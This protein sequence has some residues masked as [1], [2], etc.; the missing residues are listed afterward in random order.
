MLTHR[1]LFG[2]AFGL[3]ALLV[4]AAPSCGPSPDQQVGGSSERAAPDTRFQ[5]V[6]A[7]T[8]ESVRSRRER[9]RAAA[10]HGFVIGRATSLLQSGAASSREAAERL[11]EIEYRERFGAVDTVNVDPKE[12]LHIVFHP[13]GMASVLSPVHTQ[14]DWDRAS[15]FATNPELFGAMNSV[16]VRRASVAIGPEDVAALSFEDES[17]INMRAEGRD[18]V[19]TLLIGNPDVEEGFALTIADR[20]F[21]RVR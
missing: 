16:I 19:V 8:V 9:T 2:N 20:Q 3:L 21:E 4:L 17:Q 13:G 11:A 6:W 1:N 15:A 12:E 14:I 18:V 7:E 5:G 10:M